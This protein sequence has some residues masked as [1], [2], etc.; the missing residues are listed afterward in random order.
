MLLDPVSQ[1]TEE[2]RA[3]RD[4]C[5][6][7]FSWSGQNL[8]WTQRAGK[9]LASQGKIANAIKYACGLFEAPLCV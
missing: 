7:A 5:A 6:A 4:Q 2:Q 9:V 8:L 1:R 3:A